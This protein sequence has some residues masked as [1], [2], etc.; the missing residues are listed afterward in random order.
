M[1]GR[2]GNDRVTARNLKVI[3]VDADRNLIMIKGAV[4]GPTNGMIII[5]KAIKK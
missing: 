3:K 5:R 2:L 1:A 4:P